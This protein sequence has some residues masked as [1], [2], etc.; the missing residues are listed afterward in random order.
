ML[1]LDL[2]DHLPR[3]QISSD[4]LKAILACMKISGTPDIPSFSAFHSTQEKLNKIIGLIPQKQISSL[5]NIF[6]MNPP[7]ALIS[8]VCY[9]HFYSLGY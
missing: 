4:T 3:C 9:L 5:G 1:A 8:L 7:S 2:I 6:Y